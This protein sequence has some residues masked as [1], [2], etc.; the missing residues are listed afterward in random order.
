MANSSTS[1]LI[2]TEIP[3]EGYAKVLRF[4]N[5]DVGLDAII[6]IHDLALG[7]ALGGIR[8]HPYANFDA[9]F[10][11]GITIGCGENTLT[12]TSSQAVED[13]LPSGGTPALL[14]G[15]LV[16]PAGTINNTLASQVLAVSL[17]VGFDV[18]DAD[19]ASSTSGFGS[20]PILSGAHA[21]MTVANFLTYANQVIYL[22]RP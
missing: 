3:V 6:S 17:A 18:Y 16:D 13:F 22:P 9:A 20:L 12:F 19:F 1:S 11:D 4:Q 21:G 2:V 7:P 5:P 14:S 15:A 8:I 10:P